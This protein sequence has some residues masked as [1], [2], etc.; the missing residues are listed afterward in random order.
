MKL[1]KTILVVAISF[2]TYSN[3]FAQSKYTANRYFKEL[4]Y[5]KAANAYTNIYN[6]GDD[7]YEIISR[8][9][10]SYYFNTDTKNA[11]KWYQILSEKYPN[12]LKEEHVFRYADSLK[13]NKKYDEANE[14][15]QQIKITDADNVNTQELLNNLDYYR[16]YNENKYKLNSFDNLSVNTEYSD[17]G[18]FVFDEDLYFA[19]T[20][21]TD[22]KDIYKWNE[23]PFLNVYKGILLSTNK[24]TQQE[25]LDVT[26]SKKLL[27]VH[28]KYHE[29]SAIISKDGKTMYFTRDNYNNGKKR[30]DKKKVMRLKLYKASK[31]DDKWGN[32]IELPFNSNEYS[33]GHPTLS[34]DEK[35]LYFVSDM[36]GGYG[37][38]D[39]Y[40][41]TINGNSYDSP[42]NL[43]SEINTNGR[44]M[45]PFISDDNTFYFSSDGH[46]GLGGLDVF[47][48]Y[49]LKDGSFSKPSN[50]QTPF[51]SS[52]DDFSFYIDFENKRGF[53]SSNREGGKGDDDIYSFVLE[54]I[55]IRPDCKKTISGIVTNLKTS[56]ILPNTIVSLYDYE[57]K[58]MKKD[59]A[60]VKGE[61][62]FLINCVGESYKL[63]GTK[64]DFRD[65]IENINLENVTDDSVVE[66]ALEPFIV[67]EPVVSK[68]VIKPIYFNFDKA[69][70]REDSEYELK[71]VAEVMKSHPKMI[72]KIESHT[73]SR[74]SKWYNQKL[75][76]R[77]ANSTKNYLLSRGVAPSRI[78]SAK[79]YGESRLLNRCNDANRYKCSEEEHQLN[80]RSYFIIVE[81]GKNVIIDN[82]P[83]KVIDR[84]QKR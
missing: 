55:K 77:R 5:V 37:K 3:V 36:P 1:I 13:G 16:D 41:V 46:L 29:S 12:D 38:T 42:V 81:G 63:K 65:G 35:T 70:I 57:G 33:I 26:Q 54:K 20:K 9:A 44:E 80:R 71:H 45:F 23:Q 10:D 17:F 69:E 76:Q 31:V 48:S 62:N 47:E 67:S 25:K 68:I 59:T 83:P 78:T 82:A 64:Q 66:L 2:L 61:F 28:S 51:N 39:I 27:P 49:I 73:D 72:I 34:A 32:I 15:L 21:P 79:G 56:E 43:G 30:T 60:D 11:E 18:S 53:V 6:R 24:N 84:M 22:E 75:S 19:S 74:G 4:A 40:K 7:S 14:I 50:L 52:L 58:L 8:I